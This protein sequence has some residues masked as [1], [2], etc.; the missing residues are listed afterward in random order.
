MQK[1]SLAKCLITNLDLTSLNLSDTETEIISLC[2]KAKTPC[3]NVRAVCVYPQFVSLAKDLLTN[4]GISVAT[5][6]NFP[7]GGSDIASIK[8]QLSNAAKHGADE[9]DAVFPYN[10]FFNGNIDICKKFLE[11]ITQNKENRKIKVILESGAY[12]NAEQLKSACLLCLD[13]DIDFLKTSTGKTSVSATPEAAGTILSCIKEKNQNVG[14][15]ASGGI[16]TFEQSA[17][18]YDLCQ[19]ILGEKWPTPEHF[20]IGASSLLNNLLQT[21]KEG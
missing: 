15:K 21:I 8:E 5:V 6:I 11:T 16:K 3:G 20:R 19:Q 4:T 9:I 1:S 12:K 17:I 13:Y 2:Q 10:D 14:F 7:Q 18:Y